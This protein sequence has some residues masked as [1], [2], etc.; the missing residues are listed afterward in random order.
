MRDF[1]TREILVFLA[2]AK[3]DGF[4]NCAPSYLEQLGAIELS[5]KNKKSTLLLVKCGGIQNTADKQDLLRAAAGMPASGST[6]A[7]P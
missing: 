1:Q 7:P 2:L 4:Q 5:E 3:M 6:L